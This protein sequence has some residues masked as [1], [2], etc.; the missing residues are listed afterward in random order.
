MGAILSIVKNNTKLWIALAL[1]WYIQRK[2]VVNPDQHYI[3]RQ[4]TTPFQLINRPAPQNF[5]MSE[6]A[7]VVAEMRA[8]FNTGISRPV[9]A[10]L[11][12]IRNLQRLFQENRD[13]LVEALQ[14]DLG[15]PTT[16]ALIYDLET[17][18]GEIKHV[19]SHLREWVSPDYKGQNLLTLPSSNAIYHEPMGVVL[20]LGTWNYPIMLTMVPLLGALA[21]GNMVVLK[22]CVVSPNTA[23][24]IGELIPRYIDHRWVTVVGQEFDRDSLCTGELLKHK[25]DHIFFTGSPS[26][27]KVIM[28]GAAEHLTPCTLELGGKN[29]TFVDKSADIDLAAKRTVWGRNMNGGQQC[30]SPDYVLV[31]SSVV[32]AFGENCV[33]YVKQFYGEDPKTSGYLGKIVGVKQ[34]ERLK[35]VVTTHGGKV[36]VGG[37]FDLAAKYIAPT[38]IRV[39][40]D[41]PAMEEETFGPVLLIVAVDSMDQA[42]EYVNSKPK[43]LSLY[44]FSND[45]RVTNRIVHNTSSGGVTI[46]GTLF[47]CG[48][49]DLPFGGVGDSGMGAYHGKKTFETFSHPK[50]VLRKL[51]LPDGGLL[52]DPFFLYPPWTDLKI[53]ILKNLLKIV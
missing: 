12:Q 43:P 8:S 2:R 4:P 40:F 38:V 16:E 51:V 23:K 30:I 11:E 44:V 9:S 45:N 33:K 22:P 19:L 37:D 3:I 49:P 32:D 53:T 13:K 47:H 50:P 10:R 18:L 14:K 46:N 29:P 34:C 24:L 35:G 15:R 26:V 39:G 48:H 17:P 6:L 36:L 41:S 20:V 31:H 1:I 27:G 7:G 5:K 28:R 21:A 52:S 42:I 25:F